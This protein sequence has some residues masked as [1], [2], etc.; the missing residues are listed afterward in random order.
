MAKIK[1]PCGIA[2][3]SKMFRQCPNCREWS[4]SVDIPAA[5]PKEDA[6]NIANVAP[7][8]ADKVLKTKK[9]LGDFDSKKLQRHKAFQSLI[10]IGHSESMCNRLLK[11][12]KL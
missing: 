12:V 2:Y 1:C 6:V 5:R 10:D 4:G 3:S 11:T 8:F 7:D 9:I